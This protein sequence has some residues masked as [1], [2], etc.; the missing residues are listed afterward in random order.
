MDPSSEKANTLKKMRVSSLVFAILGLAALFYLVRREGTR[1]VM[2]VLGLIGPGLAW[3]GVY[4]ILP[5]LLDALGWQRLFARPA[6]RPGLGQLFLARW[7]AESVNT[8]FPVAQVGGH[9]LRARIIGRQR[10]KDGEAG[11]TVMVDF[12][13][14]LTTQIL[15]TLLGTGLLLAQARDYPAAPLFWAT[16]IAALLIGGFFASQRAGLFSFLARRTTL[17]WKKKA[18]GLL[19]GAMNMDQTIQKIY[20]RRGQI[21]TCAGWRLIAWI[22]KAG[23]N[24]FFFFLLGAPISTADALVL[25]SLCTA[26]RS[27][28]FFVPG[29]LGVQDGSLLMIGALLGLPRDGIMALALAK[30]AR[31]LMVGLPGLLC[32]AFLNLHLN[33]KQIAENR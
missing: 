23:E 8:L 2:T 7:V 3:L 22:A 32:W 25:E 20:G 15:F 12:T 29:G 28:A 10:K 31:E 18:P 26:F 21:L 17:V 6:P 13:L 4:R 16:G 30:R 24:W 5:I 9:I 33:R 1:E 27:A 19:D 14:G 11:A